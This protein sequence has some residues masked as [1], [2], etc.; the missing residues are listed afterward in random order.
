MPT[1]QSERCS[2][3]TVSEALNCLCTHSERSNCRHLQRHLQ[4][5]THIVLCLL[6]VAWC[7]NEHLPQAQWFYTHHTT[8]HENIPISI[9]IF[10]WHCS[11]VTCG[12]SMNMKC[13]LNTIRDEGLNQIMIVV[14]NY[15]QNHPVWLTV[16]FHDCTKFIM[17]GLGLKF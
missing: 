8:T 14:M 4:Q 2:A 7:R 12:L 16:L 9:L 11:L 5:H 13:L 17:M 6:N 1:M 10:W 3:D 15:L